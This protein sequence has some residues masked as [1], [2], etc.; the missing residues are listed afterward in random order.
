MDS[1]LPLDK[2]H[3]RVI[4]LFPV[5]L[6]PQ[7]VNHAHMFEVI[8]NSLCGYVFAMSSGAHKQTHIANFQLY[9][10]VLKSVRVLNW[11]SRLYVQTVLPLW[12][13]GRR[14][15]VDGII[16]YDPYGSGIPGI[17]L[18]VVLGTKL[19]VQYMG[20]YHRLDP[21]DELVGEYGKPRKS[22]GMFKK[23]LMKAALRISLSAADAVRVLNRDQERFIRDQWPNKP[24]FRFPSFVATNYFS[25][26]VTYQGDYVLAVGYPFHRK[27][28]DVLVQAFL[29]IADEYPNMSLRIL[30]YAPA[31][32]L[33]SYRKL[34][35][36]HPRIEFIKAGWIEDVGELMRGC[37]GFVHA[38]RS[39]AM[40]RVLLEAMACRKPVVSTKTNGGLDYV[41]DGE[42]GILCEIDDVEG[43]ASAMNK[44]LTSPKLAEQMGNAG[45]EHL[46]KKFSE[47]RFS[48][49]FISMVEQVTK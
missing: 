7:K 12:L 42:T 13:L 28:F 4:F 29:K 11:I 27:G 19:I 37:Y 23:L 45:F 15:H 38:A 1:P 14:T 22:G 43:L 17:V 48:E 26:L 33:D 49:S 24:V 16:A 30:G 40:G 39:E 20:D 5:L 41:V 8:S 31:V 9:S 44:L 34:A 2:K 10:G 25:S 18:K 36:G 3:K 47:E 6:R 32:E 35:G 46:Q 21:N